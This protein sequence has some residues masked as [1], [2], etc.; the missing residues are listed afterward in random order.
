MF[1]IKTNYVKNKKSLASWTD[2]E[3]LYVQP[4]N[5][6]EQPMNF[7]FCLETCSIYVIVVFTNN[8][9]NNFKMNTI[10]NSKVPYYP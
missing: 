10:T 5:E 2:L 9:Q 7:S 8:K 6:K 4:V 1:L 3:I